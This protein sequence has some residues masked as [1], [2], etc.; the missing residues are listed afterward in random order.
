MTYT[1]A[2]DVAAVTAVGSLQTLTRS[3]EARHTSSV[4]RMIEFQ[5]QAECC[6][7]VTLIVP[8]VSSQV[9]GVMGL[10]RNSWRKVLTT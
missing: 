5:L 8:V 9:L 6:K 7:R 2:E 10:F 3:T 4:R 1:A